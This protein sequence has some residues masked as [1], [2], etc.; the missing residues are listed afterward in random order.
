M[1]L[2]SISLDAVVSLKPNVP[3][4]TSPRSYRLSE[5]HSLLRS[6]STSVKV[7]PFEF[8]DNSLIDRRARTRIR[9]HV[10]KEK[11]TRKTRVRTQ[12]APRTSILTTLPRLARKVAFVQQPF[13]SP[14]PQ[15]G[16]ELSLCPFPGELT[17][18]CRDLVYKRNLY[19]VS[20]GSSYSNG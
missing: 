13:S 17:P 2:I 20:I 1:P 14:S 10:M 4:R 8:I 7:M 18:R 15:L 11:N 6:L 19:Q 16:T 12:R 9:S 5:S 3:S